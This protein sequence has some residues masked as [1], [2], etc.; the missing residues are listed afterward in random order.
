MQLQRAALR[1]GPGLT[2]Q[3]LQVH[4]QPVGGRRGLGG[5]QP[6]AALGFGVF[7]AVAGQVDG[8]ALA[9]H[10]LRHGLAQRL[11]ATHPQ[12]QAAGWLA[13]R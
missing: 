5:Q 10:H 3:H 2:G 1:Q 13:T 7:Q 12:R 9:G 6:V 4:V 11:Q 8:A